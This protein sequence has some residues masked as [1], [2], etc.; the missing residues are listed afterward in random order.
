MKNFAKD[1]DKKYIVGCDFRSEPNGDYTTLETFKIH[2][3]GT[4]EHLGGKKIK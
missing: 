1:I 2:K 4:I 3:D